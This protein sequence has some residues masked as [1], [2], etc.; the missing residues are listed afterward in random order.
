MNRYSFFTSHNKFNN[1]PVDYEDFMGNYPY[2]EKLDAEKY[3]YN[4]YRHYILPYL[5]NTK[6]QTV[7]DVN[8]DKGWG[9]AT[10][11]EQFGF[12][13]CVGFQSDND[14]LGYCKETH[15]DVKF[16]KD[17]I[18]SKQTGADF[19][20]AIESFRYF[21]NKSALLLKLS[22]V[23]NKGGKLFIVQSTRNL[24]EYENYE[25]ILVKTHGLKPIYQN[26]ISESCNM[27]L[28][29]I[30]RYGEGMRKGMYAT[31]YYNYFGNLSRDEDYRI[32]VS[33]F[34]K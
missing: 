10:L 23:L 19:I 3:S 32:R 1:P 25:R 16:F 29:K 15:S 9:L 6:D 5:Q 17:F 14:L 2:D 7:F 33:I 24:T 13:K 12:D 30:V 26:D 27:G 28:H 8:C 34:E 4:T 11:K 18:M 21:D 22:Q 31:E 20:F